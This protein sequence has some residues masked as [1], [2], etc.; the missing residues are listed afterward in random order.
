MSQPAGGRTE[1]P[2]AAMAE[3]TG[4]SPQLGLAALANKWPS[5]QQE[6]EQWLPLM[7]QAAGGQ[8]A[9]AHLLGE[10]SRHILPEGIGKCDPQYRAVM[11]V[12]KSSDKALK[13]SSEEQRAAAVVPPC[14][15]GSE[16]EQLHGNLLYTFLQQVAQKSPECQAAWDTAVT[17]HLGR[18]QERQAA[19]QAEQKKRA[20]E[21]PPPKSD[22][23]SRGRGRGGAGSRP[24]S[25]SS[26]RTGPRPNSRASSGSGQ[27]AAGLDPGWHP[28]AAGLPTGQLP[29]MPAGPAYMGP[30]GWGPPAFGMQPAH[31]QVPMMA[32]PPM[33]PP[34]MPMAAPAGP[35]MPSTQG[36]EQVWVLI[37]G[38]PVLLPRVPRSSPQQ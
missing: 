7:Q 18:M 17:M 32:P 5:T 2:E 14:Q 20:A 6:A 23:R 28:G 30:Y 26:G 27:Q 21:G 25:R 8:E 10:V 15:S 1:P 33:A 35:A 13:H 11:D 36:G 29:V 12:L 37:D 34:P 16:Q 24:G 22:E 31:M 4:Q 38:N 9:M 19:Q 3:A